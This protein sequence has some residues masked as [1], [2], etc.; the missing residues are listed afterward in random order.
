MDDLVDRAEL[1]FGELL[2]N[3]VRHAPGPVEVTFELKNGIQTLHLIDSGRAFSLAE[4]QLPEDDFSELGRGYSSLRSSP[5]TCAWSTFPTAAIISAWRSNP[6]EGP[7]ARERKGRTLRKKGSDGCEES[8]EETHD[9][10]RKEEAPESRDDG[11]AQGRPSKKSGE[12]GRR[13]AS[14]RRPHARVK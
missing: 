3:V 1:V 13:A 12:K 11:E 5:P 8:D 7:P 6:F 2:G 14:I 9:G 10:D 4:Q